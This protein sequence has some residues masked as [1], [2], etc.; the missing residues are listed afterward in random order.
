M[1]RQG[2][3]TILTV[4][5]LAEQIDGRLVGDG[6]ATVMGVNSLEQAGPED[7]SFVTSTRK[8]RR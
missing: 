8:R 2:R 4:A 3:E 5:E 6:A 7:I 1:A